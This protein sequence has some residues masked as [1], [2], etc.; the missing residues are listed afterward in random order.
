[1]VLEL[2]YDLTKNRQ[3]H[4]CGTLGKDTH[5]YLNEGNRYR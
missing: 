1:M 5:T 4:I 3:F 2:F